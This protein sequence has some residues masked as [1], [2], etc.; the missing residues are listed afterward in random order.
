MS[1]RIAVTT[2]QS[3][4]SVF[5]RVE[6]QAVWHFHTASW[7]TAPNGERILTMNQSGTSGILRF[8]N[9]NGERFAVIVGIDN[10]QRWCDII[11]N[12]TPT[13]TGQ[14]VLS[15]YYNGGRNANIRES[16][17]SQR[18]AYLRG[19]RRI[20]IHFTVLQGNNLRAT[21]TVGQ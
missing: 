9:N 11:P 3:P 15:L 2:T 16:R 4:Q 17:F 1:F 6:Q 7:T 13:Q 14:S 21:I 5:F 8:V 12:D 18:I 20:S 10:R 19:R